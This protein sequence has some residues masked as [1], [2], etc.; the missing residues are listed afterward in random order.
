MPRIRIIEDPFDL[1]TYREV[2]TDDLLG[3]LH[4]EFPA[5]PSTGRVYRDEIAVTND[6]TPNTEEQVEALAAASETDLF[7]VVVY[8]GDPITAIITIVATLA[9][10]AAVLLFLTPKIPKLNSNDQSS[11]NSLGERVNKPRPNERIP[12]I[13][14][15]VRSIPDLITVPYRVYDANYRELEISYMCIGRGYYQVE[16]IRDGDTL[17]ADIAGASVAVYPPEKSPNNVLDVPDILIGT[18]ISD[19][20]FNVFR[21]NDVNGQVL[22]APNDVA[23]KANAEIT[24]ADGGI[25]NAAAGSGIDFTQFFAVDDEIELDRAN[26]ALPATG[27][28][29][30]ARGLI[31]GGL[32]FT[33]FDPT[34]KF[35]PGQMVVVRNAVYYGESVAADL[36]GPVENPDYPY[37]GRFDNFNF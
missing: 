8:P 7:Y 2:Q 6:V 35:V 12:D 37:D 33:G 36:T 17:V 20:V 34:T 27:I 22:K 23:V 4:S 11:N 21:S 30:A 28:L 32:R 3:T 31:A 24:F 13:F 5:W 16:D 26:P 15:T 1:A 25:I 9:L 19:P 10:T 14:G 18:D 29:V